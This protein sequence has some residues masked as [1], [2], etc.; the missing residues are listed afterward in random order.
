[1]LATLSEIVRNIVV[2]IILVTILELLLPKSSFRP[3]VNMVVGLVLMLMLLSPLRTLMQVPG[4]IDPVWEMHMAVS[5]SDMAARQEML[6]QINW[7]LTL[8]RYRELIRERVVAVL[9]EEGLTVDQ[10][11]VEMEED[12]NSLE[13]GHPQHIFIVARAVETEE[14]GGPGQVEKIRIELGAQSS[15]TP[16]DTRRDPRLERKIA[17]SMGLSAQ[18][19]EVQVLNNE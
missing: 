15:E 18:K 16:E 13:F 8:D 7:D 9:A 4:A 11:H 5:E 6:E 12:A 2:L 17:E 3:F 1:M 14:S 19:V 10:W